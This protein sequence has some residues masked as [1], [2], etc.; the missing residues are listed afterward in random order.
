MPTATEAEL[1][2]AAAL[3]DDA[4]A[5]AAGRAETIGERFDDVYGEILPLAP[6][7]SV[8]VN[9]GFTFWDWW[10]DARNHQWLYYDG[11]SESDWPRLARH[12]AHAI[13][14]GEPV[15]DPVLIRHFEAHAKPGLLTRFLK[16]LG[17]RRDP[18]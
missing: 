7:F 16:W 1:I 3:R 14:S 8:G 2:L 5:Q 4:D 10:I 6:T 11:I 18:A 12:V 13:E 17:V 9:I 15:S